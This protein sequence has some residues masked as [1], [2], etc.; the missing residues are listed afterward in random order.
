M[1]EYILFDLDGTLTD[2]KEGITKSVQFALYDQNIKEPN[3]KKLE[4]FIGPPLKESFME[5]Y[6]MNE[7]QAE[8]AI[9]KYRER[10]QSVG[11]Y[12][13]KIYIGIHDLLDKLKK[14]GRKIAIASSKPTV[15]VEK[16]LKHFE[17]IDFF[18]VVVGS[19]LNGGRSKKE[20]VV[21]EALRQ[22]FPKGNI[23]YEKTVMIGDRRFDME[24]A[25]AFSLD[26]IGVE[27]G[28]ALRGELKKAGATYIV[29]SVKQLERLLFQE[30]ELKSEKIS[31]IPPSFRMLPPSFRMVGDILLPL[32]LYYLSSTVFLLFATFLVGFI[33][34]NIGED[35]VAW[36]NQN[37]DPLKLAINGAAMLAGFLFI[38]KIFLEEIFWKGQRITLKTRKIFVLWFK[39]GLHDYRTKLKKLVPVSLLAIT[40]ALVLNIIVEYVNLAK[41]STSYQEVSSAQYAVPLWLGL[42]LYGVVSPFAEEVL[43]RGIIYNKLKKHF[44]KVISI[45]LSA[46]LFGAY[47]G[48]VVSGIYGGIMGLLITLCYE[49]YGSFL[50]P[51][52]FHGT[53][54]VIVFLLTYHSI[55]SEKL[56]NP[57]NCII[58]GIISVSTLFY[59]FK[60]KTIKR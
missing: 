53:A 54:N 17:I 16:I 31:K 6:Q 18:D 38:Q 46:V 15:F 13:N 2:P 30:D 58:F 50:V 19:E 32:V 49:W 8:K 27:Y 1:Y 47:H 57:L 43:F 10:F 44:P 42:I 5:F 21:E 60:S 52:A 51:L 22:L 11:L 14:D 45:L 23:D 37:S 33:S 59:I 39:E 12:E 40:S 29:K 25:A 56:A 41:Y 4:P 20:E 3:L 36:V 24:G 28:F 55:L 26:S 9:R 7:E 34:L 35:S 48:N